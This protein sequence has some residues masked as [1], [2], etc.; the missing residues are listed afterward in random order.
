MTQKTIK[1]SR[2]DNGGEYTSTTFKQFCKENGI[3]HQ[4]TTT[5]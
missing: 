1:I 3:L 2:S 4:Y 5:T